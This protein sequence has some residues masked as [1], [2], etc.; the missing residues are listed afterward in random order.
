MNI[1]L[2]IGSGSTQKA[3]ANKIHQRFPL[4]GIIIEKYATKKNHTVRKIIE[5]IVEK[6]FL[7]SLG[8]S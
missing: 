4:S 7:S 3:L 5:K 8:K 1:V 2:W 6:V